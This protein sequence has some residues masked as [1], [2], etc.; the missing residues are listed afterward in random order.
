MGY[1]R[2]QAPESAYVSLMADPGAPA[3]YQKFGFEFTAP[4]SVGMAARL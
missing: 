4:D 3:L 1:L 2:D